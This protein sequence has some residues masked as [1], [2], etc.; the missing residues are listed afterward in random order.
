ML[1]VP[2][3]LR[4]AAAVCLLVVPV[5]V[6]LGGSASHDARV[7][8][9]NADQSVFK[10]SPVNGTPELELAGLPLVQALAVNQMNDDIW[11]YSHRHLLAFDAQG[12]QLVNE[13]LPRALRS[14]NPAGMV[15]DGNA[16]KLWLGMRRQLYQF[17][18]T[19]KLQAT[20]DLQRR[21][22]GLALDSTRSHLWVAERDQLVVLDKT[23]ATLFTVPQDRPPQALAYDANLDQVWVVSGHTVS[24]YD[25]GG[26]QVF[27]TRVQGDIND[28]IAPDGQGNL[29]VA[30]DRTLGYLDESGSLAFTLTPFASDPDHDGDIDQRSRIVDLVADPL[31]HTAWVANA[32][33]LEQYATDGTL[34][35]TIDIASFTGSPTCPEPPRLP[36]RGTGGNPGK[37]NP[38]VGGG[39]PGFWFGNRGVHHVALYVDT[40]PPTI[41][42]TAPKDL[43]YTNHDQPSF[44][45][46][47]SDIGSGVDPST[48]V[49]TGDGASLP[50][51]C[52][53]GN[54]SG[55]QCTVSAVLSDGTYT[56]SATVADYAGNVSKPASV[57]FTIDTVPPPLPVAALT[58]FEPGT[59]GMVIL[60]GQAGSVVSDVASVSVTNIRTG[61]KV[62]GAVNDNGSFSIPIGGTSSDEF[63]ITLTDLAGNVT[64]PFYMHGGDPALRLTITSPT[65]G[66]T[67]ASDVVNVSG[68]F[69][70]P[71]NT[72]ITV[73]GS[74]AILDGTQWIAN[75]VSLAT[76]SDTL[77]VTA[78]TSGGL[79]ATQTLNVTSSSSAPLILSATPSASGVAPFPVTFQYQFLGQAVPQS[80]KIDYTGSGNYVTVSD[81]TSTLSYAYASPGIYPVTLILTD[82]NNTQYQA[83][84]LI[85]VQDPD[86]VDALFKGIWNDMTTALAS[87]NKAAAMNALDGTAQQ[88]YGTAFDVLLPHM[89]QIV[90]TFSPLL[91]SFVQGDI[92][93]YAVVRPNNGQQELFFI[94]FIQDEKGIWR[95]DS[96]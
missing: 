26:N 19:G 44:S 56:L 30:G 75:N 37:C 85:V 29:W 81:P 23:G 33:Y 84:V 67:I 62:T 7:L 86:Q 53:A 22:D 20:F 34:K 79:S 73:N 6:I 48:L 28:H 49:I 87:D 90:S 46:T 60:R 40:I 31:N 14:G 35:Q 58:A 3:W 25:A 93:E 91:R 80:L 59:D 68:T 45:L 72:G 21:V 4:R 82:A 15:V 54:S 39:W 52:Q 47:W 38:W 88:N 64:V 32:R 43:S 94:D 51:S 63:S 27:T 57:T 8:W 10:V 76:G 66:A 1:G 74:P 2:S 65:A 69:Q 61:Q 78:T 42:F 95:V 70:G 11:V 16:G 24:R 17:D 55:V 92:G 89:Q 5:S 13:P 50:I 41:T 36:G 77:I 71:L 96:M 9:V 83:Q 18:L 12:K